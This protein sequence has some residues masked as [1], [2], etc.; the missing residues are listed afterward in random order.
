M[1]R[2]TWQEVLHLSGQTRY[3]PGL[4]NI[5]SLVFLGR[6][7]QNNLN[8]GAEAGHDYSDSTPTES[9]DAKWSYFREDSLLHDFHDKFHSFYGTAVRERWQRSTDLFQYMHQ[10]LLRRYVLIYLIC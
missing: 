4:R 1:G 5:H 9:D 7:E 6:I 3:L 10:Q 2:H 8:P